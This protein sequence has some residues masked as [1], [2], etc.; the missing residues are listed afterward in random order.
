MNSPSS[1]LFSGLALQLS[2]SVKHLGHIFTSDLSDSE[3]VERVRKD[4]IRKANCM[5]H[6]FASVI[7]RLNSPSLTLAM[8]YSLWL[9]KP[10]CEEDILNAAPWSIRMHHSRILLRVGAAGHLDY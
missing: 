7:L 6:S 3:E 1:F 8:P 9:L 4:F 2:H 10:N 5:L